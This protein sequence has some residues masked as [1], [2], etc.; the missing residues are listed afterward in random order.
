MKAEFQNWQRVFCPLLPFMIAEKMDVIAT[1]YFISVSNNRKGYSENITVTVY[2]S[3]CVTCAES[4]QCQIKVSTN[5]Y[6][7]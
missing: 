4:L 2:D 6:C 1:G 7:N 3:Q 5:N